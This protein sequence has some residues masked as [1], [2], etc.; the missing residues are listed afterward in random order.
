MCCREILTVV[1]LFAVALGAR[2]ETVVTACGSDTAGGGVNLVT[3]LAAGGDI[4][5]ACAGGPNEIR[6]G[7]ERAL[8]SATTIDGG[9]VTLSGPGSGVM[10]VPAGP[11]PLTLRNMTLKNPPSNPADPNVF[12]GIV[13]DSH[14]VFAVELSNVTVTDT[15]LPFAVRKLV[16]R[17]STFTGNGDANNSDFGVVMA[18]ELD[19]EQVTFR[20]NLSRPFH[21]LWRSDPVASGRKI[22]ARVRQSTFERNKRPA[23]WAAGDLVVDQSTFT[24]NGD[25]LPF[26]AGG[27][28]RLYADRIYLELARSAAGALEVALASATISRS[29]F[30]GNRGMLGGALLAS[31]SA[32][33]LQSSDFDANRAVSGGAVAYL[34]P[35]G[36][37][38][39]NP[40]LRLLFGHV[41]LR[42][43]QATKD[44]GAL[45]LLGDV[46]GDAVQ[47]SRNK[48]G[49]SGGAIAVASA[50]ASPTE[51]VPANVANELPAP[52]TQPTR[53]ELMR[54]FVLDNSA[55]QHAVDAGTGILRFGNALFAR[56]ASTAGGAA[57]FAQNVELA[58]STLIGNQSEGL[59][60]APGGTQG[61]S[62]ANA[63]L[64]GNKGNCANAVASLKATGANLQH[65]DGGC[66]A[67]IPVADPSLDARFAPTMFSAAR[68][69]GAMAVCAA[70]DLV[71]GRDLYGN[72]RSGPKCALGAVEADLVNDV[73]RK[74]G[75]DKF[76]WLLFWL[77][78]FLLLCLLIG[79]FVGC[80]RRRK[81]KE[82]GPGGRSARSLATGSGA[83]ASPPA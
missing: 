76:P 38:P 31:R 64:A 74:V 55:A 33:T 4:R 19:L 41:K 53:V 22:S 24:D 46:S 13:Y 14:D 28:G 70:H 47:M 83:T 27:R 17:A 30:K 42:D 80:Y 61:A 58:N 40:R 20:D 21:A 16:A 59:H 54:V 82:S 15:R 72:P 34:A 51:A 25:A 12:T 2:A 52:G 32:L 45:L 39:L 11:A 68:D 71:D 48:A 36:S 6:L 7:A 9:G 49:E 44:G 10:F 35:A 73:I 60:I 8:P 1:L 67:T 5:I 81:K 57:L 79:V 65:P 23:F 29:T 26:V 78:V 3:A 37:N 75:A 77:L 56:N 50:S 69:A 63:I 66:G 62:I 43:N 18:G